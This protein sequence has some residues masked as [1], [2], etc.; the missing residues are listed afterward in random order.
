MARGAPAE[1]L[2]RVGR[3]QAGW[4]R[5]APGF[6]AAKHAARQWG[7]VD[8][9]LRDVRHVDDAS[10]SSQLSAKQWLGELLV[11]GE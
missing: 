5:L 3:A 8:G 11:M 6:Q 7:M 1:L 9:Y 4:H 2:E 10:C